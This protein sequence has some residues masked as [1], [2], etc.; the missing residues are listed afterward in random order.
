[1]LGQDRPE[2]TSAKWLVRSGEI[3]SPRQTSIDKT[4]D[5]CAM[6][7]E[8]GVLVRGSDTPSGH[9]VAT[10]PVLRRGRRSSVWY[11]D[12]SHG[13]VKNRPQ[14][15]STPLRCKKNTPFSGVGEDRRTRRATS[16]LLDRRSTWHLRGRHLQYCC[17]HSLALPDTKRVERGLIIICRDRRSIVTWAVFD[18]RVDIFQREI[19]GFHRGQPNISPTCFP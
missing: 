16:R 1:M 5:D 8:R 19:K 13:C 12:I 2:R 17:I 11:K 7:Y 14:K 9:S 15:P 4:N 10:R 3:P 18:Q 6:N